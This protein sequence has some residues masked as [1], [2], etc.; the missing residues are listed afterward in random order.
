[1]NFKLLES[2]K[3]ICI[4]EKSYLE[5]TVV[6]FCL[7]P[8]MESMIPTLSSSSKVSHTEAPGHPHDQELEGNFTV[9]CAAGPG[10]REYEAIDLN[11]LS[12]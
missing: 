2:V 6:I 8:E 12:A 4:W 1:M 10:C 9:D 7:V 11:M 5:H 3:A